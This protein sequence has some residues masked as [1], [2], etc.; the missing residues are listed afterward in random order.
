MIM[1]HEHKYAVPVNKLE[2]LRSSLL[3][4]V[5]HDPFAARMNDHYYTTRSVYFDTP[6]LRAFQEKMAGVAVRRKF[7]IRGYDSPTGTSTVF[8]EIKQK[9]GQVGF[10]YRSQVQFDQLGRLLERRE[11]ER[12]VIPLPCADEA[13]EHARRFL[14]GLDQG[15]MR[16][17][18]LVV[19]DREAFVS[20]ADPRVRI[21]FDFNI[22]CSPLT[23]IS[24][25]Y[26]EAQLRP[27]ASGYAVLEIKFEQGYGHWLRSIVCTHGLARASFSKY[28]HSL[29]ASHQI[30]PHLS[31]RRVRT[32]WTCTLRR[33]EAIGS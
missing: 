18:V 17:V 10:K 26:D 22:R 33:P 12:C 2:A 27:V 4:Y 28:T 1:R 19:Y 16:P 13:Y 7:R 8:L 25:L 5:V 32:E 14:F 9:I 6:D 20:K 3:P 21:T 15:R 31:P 24:G 11:V 23:A 29:C 30:A